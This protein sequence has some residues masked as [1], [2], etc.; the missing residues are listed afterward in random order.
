MYTSNV[1]TVM[2]ASPGDVKDE[3]YL[4]RDVIMEWNS[5]HSESRKIVLL[6]LMWEFDTYPEM[7]DRPQAL[8]NKQMVERADVVIAVFGARLGSNTGVAP[9]GTVE[10]INL[11]FTK[12]RPVMLYF[13]NGSIDRDKFDAQQFAALQKYKSEL[14]SASLYTEFDSSQDFRTK[15]SNH[16]AKLLNDKTSFKDF[17]NGGARASDN[18]QLGE[19]LILSPAMQVVLNLANN[20]TNKR[21][22]Q[23]SPG[24]TPEMIKEWESAID[25]LVK[26]GLLK[27][28]DNSESVVLT[29]LGIKIAL[30]NTVKVTSP[31]ASKLLFKTIKSREGRMQLLDRSNG[32]F[33][34]VD[35]EHLIEDRNV[36][37]LAEYVAALNELTEFGLLEKRGV[38]SYYVTSEAF[39]YVKEFEPLLR[40]V[41]DKSILN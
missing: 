30:G 36:K 21:I 26:H 4:A 24:N 18:A 7:G 23:G 12:Q 22:E 33:M 8:I 2:I 25:T 16:L 20:S 6:P 35:N 28:E 14:R 5:N 32:L 41:Y 29:P 13:S 11:Q 19:D 17:D 1:Y 27:K 31:R 3:R 34:M 39:R 10:E 15:L 38:G 37:T 40:N 9:S